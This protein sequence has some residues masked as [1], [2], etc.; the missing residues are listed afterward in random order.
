M[1]DTYNLHHRALRKEL[2]PLVTTDQLWDRRD[3]KKTKGF[4]TL[5][6]PMPLILDIMD[7][8]AGGKPLSST[9]LE[10]WSRSSDE[11]VVNLSK[12]R[13]MAFHAG[14]SGQ[15]GERTWRGRMKLLEQLGFIDIKSGP[16]GPLS[17][18]LIFN[19]YL[20]IKQHHEAD[21]PGLREDKY[22]ALVA[23]ALEI[24]ATDLTDAGSAAA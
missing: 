14:F 9:Y 2:W 23:R 13:D 24:K 22:N 6:R 16:S 15:R 1:R 10:L 20:V 3:R 19:P 17:Y 5:P 11:C 8:M 4:M 18:A 21:T 7:D 12:A